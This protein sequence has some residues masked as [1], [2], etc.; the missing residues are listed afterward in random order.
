VSAFTCG[1]SVGW[2]MDAIVA[3]KPGW[4]LVY[5]G[6]AALNAVAWGMQK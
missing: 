3:G 1:L 2:L 5:L 4:A 6:L